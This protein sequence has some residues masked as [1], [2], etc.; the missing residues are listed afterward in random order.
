MTRRSPCHTT[1]RLPQGSAGFFFPRSSGHPRPERND[2]RGSAA[3]GGEP[4]RC[5]RPPSLV[6]ASSLRRRRDTLADSICTRSWSWRAPGKLEPGG[7][8]AST[9]RFRARK[10]RC[11]K[12][13]VVVIRRSRSWRSCGRGSAAQRG[14]VAGPGASSA[15]SERGQ[16]PPLA[17]S[18][19]RDEIERG[20][21]AEGTGAGQRPAQAVA[22]RA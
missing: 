6:S 9:A 2:R 15:R 22:R 16:L 14:A 21:A 10:L 3:R 17:G 19:R 11:R 8:R 18:V 1:G 7:V 4:R 12:A 5:A 13:N 20:E